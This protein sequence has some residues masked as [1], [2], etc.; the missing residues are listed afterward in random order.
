[1]SIS[2]RIR[3]VKASSISIPRSPAKGAPEGNLFAEDGWIFRERP[4][5]GVECIRRDDEAQ[6]GSVTISNP[7]RNRYRKN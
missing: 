6:T 4:G 2:S 3:E 1:M 7:V 5:K